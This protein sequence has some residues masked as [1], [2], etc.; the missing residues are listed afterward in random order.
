MGVQVNNYDDIAACA[1]KYSR[2]RE[3]I[4]ADTDVLTEYEVV[5]RA[6]VEL[7]ECLISAGWTPTP[8]VQ[9][10]LMLDRQILAQ[11][12]GS[13]EAHCVALTPPVTDLQGQQR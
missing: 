2:S 9:Q 12:S 4:A 6:R 8:E 5:L 3:R 13:I 11:P 7:A 10:V 1:A